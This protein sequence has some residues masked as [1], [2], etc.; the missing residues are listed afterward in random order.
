MGYPFF[1][2][3]FLLTFWGK[4]VSMEASGGEVV[5]HFSVTGVP[6]ANVCM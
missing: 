6:E 5:P 1:F 3:K 4:N 2:K